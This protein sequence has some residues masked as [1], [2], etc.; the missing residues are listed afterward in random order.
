M[1]NLSIILGIVVLSLFNCSYASHVQGANFEWEQIGKD[2]F[3]IKL[4]AYSDCNGQRF[5]P[6]D[7]IIEATGCSRRKLL[8]SISSNYDVTPVCD[9]QCTRCDSKG[10]TFKYGI[11]KYE[12]Q[13]IFVAT[14]YIK[15]GC[16]R[17]TI[18][19]LNGSRNT[20][21]TTST[22]NQSLFIKSQIIF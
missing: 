18:S 16:C 17:A 19:N 9:D 13:A 10:C 2:T 7:I 1:K 8:P 5:F 3:L 4:N 12:L 14:S 20:I 22:S 6:T 11:K 21:T 15:N